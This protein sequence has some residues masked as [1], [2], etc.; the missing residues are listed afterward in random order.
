MLLVCFQNGTIQH[1][2]RTVRKNC[3][4]SN[5]D[6]KDTDNMFYMRHERLEID[7]N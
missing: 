4:S 1:I 5:D 6:K 7:Q 2:Q 3:Q